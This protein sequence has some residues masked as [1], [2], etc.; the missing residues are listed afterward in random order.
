MNNQDYDYIKELE[1][2]ENRLQSRIDLANDNI[3][4]LEIEIKRWNK[5][6]EEEIESKTTN[7]ESVKSIINRCKV[8]LNQEKILQ[9]ELDIILNV[10]R[11][12][13]K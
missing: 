1:I 9:K 10:R 11:R 6:L 7:G 5:R 8:N 2:L 3:K 13:S 12:P 4:Y